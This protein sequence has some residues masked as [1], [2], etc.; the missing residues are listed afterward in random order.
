MTE[1]TETGRRQSPADIGGR[2]LLI[3]LAL[4]LGIVAGL[5]GIVVTFGRQLTPALV[6]PPMLDLGFGLLGALLESFLGGP[7]L[8][9][10][11]HRLHERAWCGQW[12]CRALD[13]DQR[14]GCG[15]AWDTA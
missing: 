14:V 12:P 4:S 13:R 11:H 7:V 10:L 5:F 6:S 15:C 3:T 2:S 9:L 1:K 8:D